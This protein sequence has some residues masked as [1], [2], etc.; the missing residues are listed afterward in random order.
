MKIKNVKVVGKN[1]CNCKILKKDKWGH[2]C[3]G[4]STKQNFDELAHI[5]FLKFPIIKII[6]INKVKIQIT[7]LGKT[8]IWYM[9]RQNLV[10]FRDGEFL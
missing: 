2:V 5:H 9:M 7:D 3:K 10:A 8:S 6:I 1:S 4:I